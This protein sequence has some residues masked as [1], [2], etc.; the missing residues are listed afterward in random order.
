MSAAVIPLGPF[1]YGLDRP[2]D[3]YGPLD[4]LSIFLRQLDL[5][6]SFHSAWRECSVRI[7]KF[8][9]QLATVVGDWLQEFREHRE[10]IYGRVA[11]LAGVV[12][13]SGTDIDQRFRFP[14]MPRDEAQRREIGAPPAKASMTP[15]AKGSATGGP[16]GGG[17]GKLLSQFSGLIT[18]PAAFLFPGRPRKEAE[19]WSYEWGTNGATKPLQPV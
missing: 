10:W 13:P 6:K 7:T 19:N 16:S 17:V 5:E 1:S 15:K 4:A 9:E 11:A 18:K 12:S 14:G 2:I 3:N 8:G